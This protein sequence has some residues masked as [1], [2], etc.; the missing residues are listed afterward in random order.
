[1]RRWLWGGLVV[2]LGAGALVAGSFLVWG[3]SLPFDSQAW[4]S[5]ED[6]AGPLWSMMPGR[7]NRRARMLDDLL[8]NHLRPGAAWPPL[9][10]LLG[11]PGAEGDG[12][13]LYSLLW[14]ATPDQ[15]LVAWA[16]WHTIDPVLDVE[17]RED[18]AGGHVT[19][20]SVR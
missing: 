2:L 10:R 16:K 12:T 8:A 5:L 7:D 6:P 9:K 13:K 17:V 4:L 15:E 14:R 19:E 18:A 1:M 20:A 11:R 3:P